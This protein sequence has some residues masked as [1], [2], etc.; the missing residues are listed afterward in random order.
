MGLCGDS[1]ALHQVAFGYRTPGGAR[2]ALGGGALSDSPPPLL[3]KL[4]ARLRAFAAGKPDD[5]ADVPV[6]VAGS[7]F[8]RR[9]IAAC[10][11]IG[12]GKTR[13]YAELAAAAGAPAAARAAGRVMATN[14]APLVVPCHRVVGRAG[15]LTGYSAMGGLDTKRRLL[16][17]EQAGRSGR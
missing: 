12:Y 6:H 9:V 4:A 10:R 17:I 2:A 15:A 3:R 14:R 16:E 8:R 13:T 5:F 1:E 7:D 11:R